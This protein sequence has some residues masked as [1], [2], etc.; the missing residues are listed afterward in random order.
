[1]DKHKRPYRCQDSACSTRKGFTSRGCLSRHMRSVHKPTGGVSFPCLVDGCSR[2]ARNPFPRKDNLQSHLNHCHKPK[3]AEPSRAYT[4]AANTSNDEEPKRK[5]SADG[6]TTSILQIVSANALPP[7][8]QEATAAALHPLAQVRG[9]QIEQKRTAAAEGEDATCT[10]LRDTARLLEKIKQD[11]DHN[12]QSLG[13][14]LDI[15][16]RS[17]MSQDT[18]F[19]EESDLAEERLRDEINCLEKARESADQDLA[20]LKITLLYFR[21]KS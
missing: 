19:S 6:L 1:V 12:L 3:D 8:T 10:R 9:S 16:T 15:L 21:A 2:D 14:A 18:A 20:A 17:P 7:N 5:H 4:D 13:A 11:A